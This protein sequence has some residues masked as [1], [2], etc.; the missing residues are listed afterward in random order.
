MTD[1]DSVFTYSGKGEAEV[2]VGREPQQ[3]KSSETATPKSP[4]SAK[5][6]KTGKLTKLEKFAKLAKLAKVANMAKEQMLQN[7]QILNKLPMAL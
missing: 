1:S 4:K 5:T 2:E 3:G 6:G 7:W